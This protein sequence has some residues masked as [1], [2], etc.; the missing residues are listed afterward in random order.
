MG[1]LTTVY[2]KGRPGADEL[3]TAGR[4]SS[5]EKSSS[6]SLVTESSIKDVGVTALLVMAE[7]LPSLGN[8]LV[9]S[10]QHLWP[11]HSSE[12]PVGQGTLA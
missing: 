4:S 12:F 11:R 2:R 6:K 9:P 1:T 10:A 8:S 3:L 7:V 5:S